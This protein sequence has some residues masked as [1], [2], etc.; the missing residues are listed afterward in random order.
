MIPYQTIEHWVLLFD[1]VHRVWNWTKNAISPLSWEN[2][3]KKI[4]NKFTL[5][6]SDLNGED[7]CGGGS[8][9]VWILSAYSST[10]LTPFEFKY[11]SFLIETLISTFYDKHCCVCQARFRSQGGKD[12]NGKI[13]ENGKNATL[14]K[15]WKDDFCVGSFFSFTQNSFIY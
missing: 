8:F 6:C 2:E 1:S 3:W 5:S 9:E 13:Y 15:F 10:S 11:C 4:R 14:C 12:G 7:K